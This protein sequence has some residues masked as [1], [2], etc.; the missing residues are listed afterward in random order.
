MA[1]L[2]GDHRLDVVEAQGEAAFEEKVHLGMGLPPDRAPPSITRVEEVGALAAARPLRIRARVHDRKSPTRPEDWQS[3]VLR[4]TAAGRTRETPMQ[5][6]GE[7][8]WRG[9]IDEPPTGVLHYQVCATDAAGNR[10]CSPAQARARS[11]QSPI[12]T[13]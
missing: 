11:D 7:Y 10:A 12:S 8:L 1:D 13:L 2:D 3:V 6:Y 9:S 4:W 5:W